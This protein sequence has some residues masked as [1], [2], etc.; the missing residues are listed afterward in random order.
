[1]FQRGLAA[2]ARPAARRLRGVVRAEIPLFLRLGDRG[3]VRP[4]EARLAPGRL[5]R[6]V[7]EQFTVE[8]NVSER[9]QRPASAQSLFSGGMNDM[10]DR[11]E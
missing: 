1:M 2:L 6:I 7:F 9:S 4:E 8:D 3:R 5:R 11:A 10:T